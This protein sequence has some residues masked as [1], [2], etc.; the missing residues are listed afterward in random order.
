M[1]VSFL[2]VWRTRFNNV[3]T[4]QEFVTLGKFLIFKKKSASRRNGCAFLICNVLFSRH[5]FAMSCAMI[6]L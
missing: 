4:F 6:S 2:H 1:D 3:S 5:D